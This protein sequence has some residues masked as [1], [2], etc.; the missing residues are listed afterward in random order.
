[1][2]SSSVFAGKAGD[3]ESSIDP[4]RVRGSSEG[5]PLPRLLRLQ[6]RRRGAAAEGKSEALFS[7][8]F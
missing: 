7:T 6:R 2:F 8:S 5:A 3:A 1:M 4:A